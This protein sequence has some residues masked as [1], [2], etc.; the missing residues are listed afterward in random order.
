M[1]IATIDNKTGGAKL[2]DINPNRSKTLYFVR[3]TSTGAQGTGYL[4]VQ[5]YKQ[6]SLHFDYSNDGNDRGHGCTFY[7]KD[8]NSLGSGSMGV[9]SW[10]NWKDIPQNAAYLYGYGT[11]SSYSTIY[12]ALKA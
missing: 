12:F 6:Y 3:S 4:P 8:G 11:S 1:A 9:R 7:D 5:G 10:S 2:N